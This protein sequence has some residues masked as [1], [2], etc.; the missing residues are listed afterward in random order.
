MKNI[1][2]KACLA[3][4]E[5]FFHDAISSPYE[6]AENWEVYFPLTI[7]GEVGT[8]LN[9]YSKQVRSPNTYAKEIE[10]DSADIFIVLIMMGMTIEK[11]K[12]KNILRNIEADWKKPAV[13]LRNEAA[14][15]RHVVSLLQDVAKL[16]DAKNH[17]SVFFGK[18]FG[19]IK[20][21]SVYATGVPWQEI[22]NDFHKDTL[23]KFTQF[24]RYTPDL[25]YRGSC[26][27]DFSLLLAW[28]K[29]NK[30]DLPGKRILFLERMEKLQ[31]NATA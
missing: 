13:L 24:E 10:N 7:L 23:D 9:N 6:L 16:F 26:Y 27:V 21:V 5:I 19:S 18:I 15:V 3:F 22:I 30:A 29:K 4:Q 17:T 25:W 11:K 12:G 1:D 14:F 8:L 2:L 20:S 28:I 31:K